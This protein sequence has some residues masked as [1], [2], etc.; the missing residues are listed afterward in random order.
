MACREGIKFDDTR[1]LFL[2]MFGTD[3]MVAGATTDA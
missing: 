2:G 1:A 3:G